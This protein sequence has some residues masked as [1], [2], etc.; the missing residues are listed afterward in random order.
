V[1]HLASKR[2]NPQRSSV[3]FAV[4]ALPTGTYHGMTKLEPY[5]R[6]YDDAEEVANELLH[7]SEETFE[8]FKISK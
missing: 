6:R 3:R 4:A 1:P 2:L 7:E 8:V 5:T